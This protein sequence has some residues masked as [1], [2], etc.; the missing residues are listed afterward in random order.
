M[1]SKSVPMTVFITPDGHY[2]FLRVP[3]GLKN[4]PAHFSKIMYQ[5]LGDLN[6]FVKIYLDDITVHSSSFKDHLQHLRT[7]I[8]RLRK[9][10]LMLNGSKCT[11]CSERIKILGHIIQPMESS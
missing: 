1:S 9:A 3:F 8:K 11:W 5:I 4:A 6:E 7:V 2:E 10:N